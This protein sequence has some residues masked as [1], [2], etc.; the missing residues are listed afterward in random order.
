MYANNISLFQ[1]INTLISCHKSRGAK[2]FFNFSKYYAYLL[3]AKVNIKII[4]D[5][6]FIIYFVIELLL[7]VIII[8]K[9]ILLV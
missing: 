7:Q 3:T 8:F 4:L 5:K 9:P 1:E 2:T 6:Y